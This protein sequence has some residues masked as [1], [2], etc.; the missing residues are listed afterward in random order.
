MATLLGP[1]PP[2]RQEQVVPPL[3]SRRGARWVSRRGVGAH[4]RGRSPH[5]VERFGSLF[6]HAMIDL[7]K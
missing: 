2:T 1:P 6:E 3:W 4:L 5:L 7:M